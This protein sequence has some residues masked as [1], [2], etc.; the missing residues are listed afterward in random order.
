VSDGHRVRYALTVVAGLLL[1][2]VIWAIVVAGGWLDTSVPSIG[3][4]LDEFR[5]ANSRASLTRAVR[6]TGGEA[7]R[8]FLI[9]LVLAAAAGV[10]AVL[11]PHLRRGLDQLAT[12]ENAVPLVALG[13]ILLATL[14]R[15]S[16]PVA[17]SAVAVFFTMYVGVTTGLSKFSTAHADLFH[18]FGARRR[19]RLVRLQIPSAI[20]IVVTSLKVAIPYA[21]VGAIIGEWF[22]AQRGLGPVML[23]AMQTYRMPS[24][25]AGAVC[26]VGLSLLLYG[27]M[28]LIETQTDRRFRSS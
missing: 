4:V 7:V 12:F 20:P 2:L 13:P 8:G 28:A 5:E 11:V 18:V 1:V 27:A 25:W 17:M 19:D 3:S 26:A 21:I 24:L 23:V 6:V 9:G 16:V 15:Q 14:D 10:I 22:G